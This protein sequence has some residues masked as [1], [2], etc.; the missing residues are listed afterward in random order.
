MNP[1]SYLLAL[2][3]ASDM[4]DWLNWSLGLWGISFLVVATLI[5]AATR[6]FIGAVFIVAAVLSLITIPAC[7]AASLAGLAYGPWWG[8][9]AGAA[10]L[11]VTLYVG[12][13]VSSRLDRKR[14]KA[15]LKEREQS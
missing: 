13:K 14:N 4:S 8:A 1:S 11:A 6:D 5:V 9:S 15:F 2:P 10:T 3:P 7:V 12:G